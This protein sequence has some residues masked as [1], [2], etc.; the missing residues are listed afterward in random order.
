MRKNHDFRSSY[1]RVLIRKEWYQIHKQ[2]RAFSSR[3]QLS[4][5]RVREPPNRSHRTRVGDDNRNVNS[6]RQSD[7]GDRIR[8]QARNT[9]PL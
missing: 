7:Y 6:I 9:A 4:K 2:L 8:K 5:R 1:S 3:L